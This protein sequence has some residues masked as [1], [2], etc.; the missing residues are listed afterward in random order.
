[1]P[2]RRRRFVRRSITRW[3]IRSRC[4]L[5]D[6]V[7]DSVSVRDGA[8]RSAALTRCHADRRM[9]MQASAVS[10][11]RRAGYASALI[12][13]AAA[14]SIV[15]PPFARTR[16]FPRAARRNAIQDCTPEQFERQLNDATP[17]R[18][19]DGYAPF[20]KLHVHPTWTSP[21]CLTSTAA[22]NWHAK[23]RRSTRSGAW[24]AVSIPPSRRRSR[25][26]R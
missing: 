2:R 1:M 18:V 10:I 16:L 3:R 26:R 22:S 4:R 15:L 11:A 25:W 5:R 8:P 19:L 6:G 24:S 13:P 14:M 20:C 12:M 21:R 17:L 23:V 9:V 7:R